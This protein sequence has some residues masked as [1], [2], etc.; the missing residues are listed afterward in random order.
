LAA[1]SFCKIST[2]VEVPQKP[3]TVIRVIG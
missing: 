3:W 2:R 1:G